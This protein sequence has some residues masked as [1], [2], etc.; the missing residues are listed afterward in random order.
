MKYTKRFLALFLALCMMLTSVPM[1]VRAAESTQSE[2]MAEDAAQNGEQ[3]VTED[4]TSETVNSDNTESTEKDGDAAAGA[5]QSDSATDEDSQD[6]TLDDAK[7]GKDKPDNVKPGKDKPENSKPGKDKPDNV[8]PGKDE[9]ENVKPGKEKPGKDEKTEVEDAQESMV[10][11]AV[12]EESTEDTLSAALAAAK[13]YIDAL[14][15]NNASNDPATVVS[16]YVKHF[17]WDNEKRESSNTYLY[18]WSY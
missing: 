7:P 14:T 1:D 6:T 9:K 10:M 17:T 18:D 13:K 11:M 15:I 8:K 12:Q 2:V 16:N 4:E 3:A 5:D